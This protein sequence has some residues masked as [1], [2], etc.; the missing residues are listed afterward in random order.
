MACNREM[1]AGASCGKLVEGGGPDEN[2][3]GDARDRN[4]KKE[5]SREK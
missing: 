5:P 2:M 4:T 1:V 3:V